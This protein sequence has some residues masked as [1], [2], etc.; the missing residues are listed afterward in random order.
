MGCE[1]AD[2]REWS[3][4]RGP[5]LGRCAHDPAHAGV[6]RLR[7]RPQRAPTARD[8]ALWSQDTTPDGFRWLVGDDAANNVFAFERIGA[9]GRVVVRGGELRRVPHEGYRVGLPRA[10]IWHGGDQHRRRACTA[11][12]GWATSGRSTRPRPVH[13]RPA[14]ATL[15]IPPLGALWLRPPD[16]R[17]KDSAEAGAATIMCQAGAEPP[18]GAAPSLEGL[19][20]PAER[21]RTSSNPRPYPAAGEKAPAAG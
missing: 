10:G 15:R 2:E 21:R 4:E 19:V 3:E 8:P 6:Q 7:A 9:D 5:G 1:L 16:A 11:A 12:P 20:A 13:G 17:L 18:G 14:S